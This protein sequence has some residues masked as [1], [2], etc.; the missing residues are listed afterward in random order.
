MFSIHVHEGILFDVLVI[1]HPSHVH[2]MQEVHFCSMRCFWGLMIL[3]HVVFES[4]QHTM[5]VKVITNTIP[6]QEH[7]FV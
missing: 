2:S 6:K 5:V 3:T 4:E 1:I 7:T